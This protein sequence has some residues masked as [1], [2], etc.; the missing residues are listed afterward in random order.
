MGAVGGPWIC[1]RR[2]RWARNSVSAWRAGPLAGGALWR[3]SPL[4]QEPP[5]VRQVIISMG[6][7]ART[8]L[9]RRREAT[10]RADARVD[11]HRLIRHACIEGPLGAAQRRRC[12]EAG[13]MVMWRT[14]PG[15]ERGCRGRNSAA[16]RR[17]P[18]AGTVPRPGVGAGTAPRPGGCQRPERRLGRGREGR[19]RGRNGAAAR[20][21]C[22]YA[23]RRPR[24]WRAITSRWIWLVPSPI[25]VSLA[26]RKKRSTG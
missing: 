5:D 19:S 25:S 2:A 20:R 12:G 23:I 8:C 26:S 4:A 3:A 18:T 7:K 16:A 6:T 13:E 10:L 1:R 17:V 24:I 22:A 9:A 11:V 21:L 14:S 15:R